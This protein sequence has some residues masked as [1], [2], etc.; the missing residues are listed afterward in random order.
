[1]KNKEINQKIYNEFNENKP[2]LF[3]SILEQCPKMTESKETDSLWNKITRL[4]SRQKL[5]YSFTTLSVIAIFALIISGITPAQE[6]IVYSVIAIDVNPSLVLELDEEDKVINVIRNNTDADVIIGSMDLVGVDYDV[7]VNALIGSMLANGYINEL[8]NSV[9]LSVQ[10]NDVV[11][12]EELKISTSQAVSNILSSNL[13]NGSVITQILKLDDASVDLAELLDISEAK[14]ELIL[15]IIELDPRVTVESLALLSVNDLNLLLESKNYALEN[16]EK[17]GNAS[18]L[19]IISSEEAFQAALT[20]LNITINDAIEFEIELEQED[21]LL[22]YE[23]EVETISS[24][25]EILVNAKDGTVFIEQLD[26]DNDDTH[27]DDDELPNNLITQEELLEVIT[28]EFGI[29]KS[30]ILEFEYDLE[31]EN[32]VAF[33]DVSF[34]YED[35][36]YDLEINALTGYLYRYSIEQEDLEYD[37]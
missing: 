9:L 30:F 37:D 4:F 10:S 19:G 25:Y 17:T 20:E 36:E 1:M 31:I 33:Y 23:I 6:S 13:I 35:S 8:A 3:Q 28:T 14:A 21:G 7:A 34:V 12:Q 11:H 24:S 15:E 16:I 29:I 26:D 5:V 32:G 27:N 22:I 18:T 2:E